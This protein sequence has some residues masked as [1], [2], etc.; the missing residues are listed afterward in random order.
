MKKL[1]IAAFTVCT[2]TLSACGGE[3]GTDTVSS[4]TATTTLSSPSIDRQITKQIGEIAG[5][6]CGDSVNEC[7]INFSVETMQ[8][9]DSC[10]DL[11]METYPDKSE[12]LQRML[13]V[14]TKIYSSPDA[15]TDELNYFLG[16]S[17]WNFLTSDGI[18]APTTEANGCLGDAMTARNDFNQPV[19][20]G[21][22]VLRHELYELPDNAERLRLITPD[23]ETYW[24]WDLAEA[25]V[26]S[27]DRSPSPVE[28]PGS[29]APEGDP[30]PA[31]EPLPAPART[32]A[33][34]PTPAPAPAPATD[35]VIGFTGAP[36]VDSP[37][38]LDKTIASCGERNLHE[39][40]TTFFTDG[41]SG[42]TQQCADQMGY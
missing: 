42:W 38:V 22:T 11:G 15:T 5:Y 7:M 28:A 31:P 27:S 17:S 14:D 34:V 24:E 3:V 33:L 16:L 39:T 18:T 29:A 13:R 35:P 26:P 37:R 8:I 2:L 23:A 12:E 21:T 36:S 32:E 19:V 6:N 1:T 10:E 4:E 20:P 9:S 40:G 30:A 25:D 41:T